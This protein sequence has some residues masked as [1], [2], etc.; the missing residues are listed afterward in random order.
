[1]PSRAGHALRYQIS[2]HWQQSRE[3]RME[4]APRNGLPKIAADRHEHRRQRHQ[5]KWLGC[6]A[7]GLIEIVPHG[8]GIAET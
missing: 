8:K 1:V 3:V 7:P 5:Y 6:V 4:S 2:Q